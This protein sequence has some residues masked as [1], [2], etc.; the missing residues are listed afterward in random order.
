MTDIGRTSI[1][2]ASDADRDAMVSVINDAFAI[3][4]FFEGPRTNID[5]LSRMMQKGIF[6][7]TCDPVERIVASV[8]VELRKPCGYIGMLSIAPRHQRRGLGRRMVYAAEDFCRNQGC[9][10]MKLTILSR[11][12]ELLPFYEKLGYRETG[13]EEF[14]RSRPLTDSAECHC[15]VMSKPL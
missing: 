12:P 8:Y 11:R 4:T 3:E 6:L 14:V 7:I 10:G 5:Q 13:T 15:I 2:I 1:R 9:D